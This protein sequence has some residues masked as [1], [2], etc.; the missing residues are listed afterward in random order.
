M[1]ITHL[2]TQCSVKGLIYSLRKH[3]FIHE[4]PTSMD[5]PY[6]LCLPLWG[7]DYFFPHNS[8]AA[9]KQLSSNSPSCN[10]FDIV[11]K[12]ITSPLYFSKL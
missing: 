10:A 2:T 11:F 12:I 4:D 7:R 3:H 5:D 1:H 6:L 8:K 9:F